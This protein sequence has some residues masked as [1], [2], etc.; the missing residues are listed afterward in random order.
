MLKT[1]LLPILLTAVIVLGLLLFKVIVDN[2]KQKESEK[3][4]MDYIVN[5]KLATYNVDFLS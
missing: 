2:Q 3:E 5:L 4:M 1:L